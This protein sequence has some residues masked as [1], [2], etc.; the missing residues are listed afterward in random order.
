MKFGVLN[1]PGSNCAEDC[2]HV[3]DKVVNQPTRYF[4]HQETNTTDLDAIVVPGGFSYG[5]YLRPGA[6]AR[7]APAMDAL[8]EFVEKG[9]LVIGICNGFQILTEAGL[10]P[11]SLIKN[12]S[13]KF[14]CQDQTIRVENAKTPF[15]QKFHKHELLM[16]PIA[17]NEGNYYIDDE[18]L[19]ELEAHH[20]I[21][22]RYASQDGTVDDSTNPNGSVSNIAGICNKSFNVL[23]MMPHP[24]RNAESLLGNAQGIKVFESM[25]LSFTNSGN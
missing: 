13:V 3:L 25:I 6:I 22:F 10:L 20:Q 19:A 23:G 2:F 8:K 24:E 12:K 11:G 15:T 16:T 5:D 4:W 21:I 7:F 18:G 1:F 17:H 9:K 14:L